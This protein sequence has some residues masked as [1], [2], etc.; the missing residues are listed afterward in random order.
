MN[1]NLLR[2]TLSSSTTT[3]LA[4]VIDWV[5]R[6][7]M[8]SRND[9]LRALWH[10]IRKGQ[11]ERFELAAALEYEVRDLGR[12]PRDCKHV[13]E[14]V[15]AADSVVAIANAIVRRLRPEQPIAP[16]TVPTTDAVT[17][18]VGLLGRVLADAARGGWY[19]R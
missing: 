15:G 11:A 6:P 16:A 14:R 13:A 4:E 18:L 10:Q 8:A 9:A 3:E 17:E 7:W 12:H 19:G 1:L 5:R 2:D